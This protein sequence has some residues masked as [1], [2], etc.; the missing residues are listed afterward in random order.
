MDK[1][2]RAWIA[3]G[4]NLGDRLQALERA[5]ARLTA[6][7]AMSF[8]AA[9]RL[10]ETEP[11]GPPGQ[12]PYL[13]AVLGLDCRLAAAALLELLLDLERALGRRREPSALRWGPR[14]ID[15][16][17]LLLGSEQICQPGLEVPHPRLGERPFVLAPLN[18]LAPELRPPGSARTVAEL[19][20]ACPLVP[21]SVRPWSASARWSAEGL[22]EG[23]PVLGPTAGN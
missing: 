6:H 12:G 15:L 19:L 23:P 16:D 4:S 22:V 10:W 2:R 7:H 3:L 5:R 9:S 11:V 21:G 13:N 1:P 18:E 8:Q 20:S 14:L 17:L